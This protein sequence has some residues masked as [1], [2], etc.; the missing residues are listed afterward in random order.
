MSEQPRLTDLDAPLAQLESVR[1]NLTVHVH[2]W[3]EMLSERRPIFHSE[4]DFQFALAML[5]SEDDQVSKIRLERRI[6][7]RGP[8][9]DRAYV[10]VDILAHLDGQPVGLEVKYPKRSLECTAPADGELED[11]RLPEGACDV[12][13]PEFW[14]DTARMERLIAEE[15]IFAGASLMLSN[16]K[17]W[18]PNRL[19]S[20]RSKAHAF[21][22]YDGRT[23]EAGQTLAW[24]EATAK[25]DTGPVH[26]QH[27]YHC[28]WQPYSIVG[29]GDTEFRYLV[30]EP[31]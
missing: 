30:L 17:L 28:R 31:V 11:F 16:Y 26:L 12:D 13:A 19:M 8:L 23:V 18:E 1:G 3:M 27:E 25:V 22:L 7:L 4:A 9:R 5:M 21:A 14:H 15:V 24:R 20:A 29:G 2:R 10:N 6:A